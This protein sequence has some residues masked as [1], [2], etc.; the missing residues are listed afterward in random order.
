LLHVSDF[1]LSIVS[2]KDPH[3]V[4]LISCG[5]HVNVSEAHDWDDL[6]GLALALLLVILA[7][8]PR[9]INYS[10]RRTSSSG[11]LSQISKL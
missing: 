3:L 8:G 6:D 7:N 9:R 2:S 10:G 5:V 4:A 11:P 1:A